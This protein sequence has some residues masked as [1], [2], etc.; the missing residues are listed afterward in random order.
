[1]RRADTPAREI[2]AALAGFFFATEPGIDAMEDKRCGTCKHWDVDKRRP[3]ISPIGNSMT[4]YIAPCRYC[5]DNP[6]LP[7]CL[8]REDMHE[9]DGENC[10]CFYSRRQFQRDLGA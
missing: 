4:F 1:M 7:D 3:C 6:A 9:V 2:R 10:P 8:I 5:V